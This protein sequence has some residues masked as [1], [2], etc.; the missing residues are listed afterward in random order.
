MNLYKNMH[1]SK[2]MF[3]GLIC[4]IKIFLK[5]NVDTTSILLTKKLIL[6]IN[7]N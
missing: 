6:K 2:N 4:V 7:N 1:K 3:Y 5:F